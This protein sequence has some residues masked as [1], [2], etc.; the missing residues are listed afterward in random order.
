MCGAV[1]SSGGRNE[2]LARDEAGSWRP[3]P[4]WLG[5]GRVG[6][7]VFWSGRGACGAGRGEG[8]G[9]DGGEV[10]HERQREG[11]GVCCVAEEGQQE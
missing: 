1:L 8:R 10:G 11:K 6:R 3:F 4:R 2:P 5:A 9:A 7:R